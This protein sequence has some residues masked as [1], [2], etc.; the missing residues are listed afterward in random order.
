MTTISK[1]L[2]RFVHQNKV[3]IHGTRDIVTAREL[4]KSSLFTLDAG[5]CAGVAG[6]WLTINRKT[7]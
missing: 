7:S 3:F 2:D 1:L 6:Y 4:C 5:E